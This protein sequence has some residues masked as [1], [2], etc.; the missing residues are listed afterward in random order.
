MRFRYA[1]LAVLILAIVPLSLAEP[2]TITKQ[3]PGWYLAGIRDSFSPSDPIDANIT[4]TGSVY[5]YG[6][7]TW[8]SDGDG[9]SYYAWVRQYSSSYGTK[10]GWL[11][12]VYNLSRSG[13]LTFDYLL[14]VSLRSCS[15]YSYGWVYIYVNGTLIDS[16]YKY[17]K[18]WPTQTFEKEGSFTGY[19]HFFNI[20]IYMKAKTEE[21]YGLAYARA[22]IDNVRIVIG[23]YSLPE[24][25]VELYPDYTLYN[26][27][28]MD[29]IIEARILK[30]GNVTQG[31]CTLIDNY[32]LSCTS[33]VIVQNS[34]AKV[35]SN[36]NYY[37]SYNLSL[38][39]TKYIRRGATIDFQPVPSKVY[40]WNG[41]YHEYG[42]DISTGAY[43]LA[44]VFENETHANLLMSNY[45]WLV[46]PEVSVTVDNNVDTIYVET[47]YAWWQDG[48]EYHYYPSISVVLANQTAT[49]ENGYA[50][51]DFNET[52]FE[53]LSTELY[54][55]DE[56]SVVENPILIPVRNLTVTQFE[57]YGE[58]VDDIHLVLNATYHDGNPFTGRI[59]LTSNA[60][61]YPYYLDFNP[62]KQ[63]YDVRITPYGGG[64]NYVNISG[65]LVNDQ[66]CIALTRHIAPE[67]YHL[68]F[69]VALVFDEVQI[70]TEYERGAILS[71]GFYVSNRGNFSLTNVKLRVRLKWPRTGIYYYDRVY[72]VSFGYWGD[73]L[74]PQTGAAIILD[75]MGIR[76]NLLE[77]NY[78]LRLTFVSNDIVVLGEIYR[79][80]YIG[81]F[82][83]LAV[84]C[85][86]QDQAPLAGMKIVVMSIDTLEEYTGITDQ[87]GIAKFRLR[88]GNYICYAENHIE[89]YTTF[90]LEGDKTLRLTAM[91]N[92]PSQK[93]E[94]QQPV[95]ITEGFL[96]FV[97]VTFSFIALIAVF[98]GG[99]GRR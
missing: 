9:Y 89:T 6:T 15:S 36:F 18:Y 41:T 93:I 16:L 66:D 1:W 81:K 55:Y 72:N 7:S 31:T 48:L 88:P 53:P 73:S 34:T 22:W 30:V 76:L 69:I 23:N 94:V 77:G 68:K 62:N 96:W 61:D 45:F 17:G 28:I 64:V 44:C 8:S 47:Y 99:G 97:L 58:R 84:A 14:S 2:I 67:N 92:K 26:L 54:V 70:E 52:W 50:Q 40:M 11:F 86:D 27:T 4:V 85:V 63:G 83:D 75:D 78:T 13:R 87:N 57:V 29:D 12:V 65:V 60:V 71:G 80:I 90:T 10:T 42:P 35:V 37:P 39:N 25:E 91:I 24:V 46:D 49:G 32:T 3:W 82:Y 74:P 59:Y 56:Y 79:T 19:G 38:E 21:S 20:S 95:S 51:V 33:N 5:D 98:R 43:K